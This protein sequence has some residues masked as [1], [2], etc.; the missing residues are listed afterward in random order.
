MHLPAAGRVGVPDR[1]L[2]LL[3]VLNACFAQA[4]AVSHLPLWM[5]TS[6]VLTLSNFYSVAAAHIAVAAAAPGTVSLAMPRLLHAVGHVGG[7]V[8]GEGERR[9][10]WWAVDDAIGSSV[11]RARWGLHAVLPDGGGD[12]T[13]V[14]QAVRACTRPFMVMQRLS[15]QTRKPSAACHCETHHHCY[16]YESII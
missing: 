7:L 16:A 9:G 15:G 2:L 4:D 6:L 10:L 5:L 8:G 1:V 13:A 11:P 3:V 14:L 12:P